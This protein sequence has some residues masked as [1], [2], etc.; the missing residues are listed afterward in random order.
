[1]DR[2]SAPKVVRAGR[3]AL[4]GRPNVGK[5]T[6]LNALLGER[7]AITSPHPQTT[8]AVVRGV[9]TRGDAQYVL[10]DTPGLH[11]AR[12]RLGQ[13]MNEAAQKTA[14][15]ADAVVFIMQ[16]PAEGAPPQPS[17]DDVALL[18]G[19]PARPTVVAVNKIDRVKK[20]DELLPFL[21]AI[22][23]LVA[24]RR[25]EAVVPISARRADGVDQLLDALRPL[26]PKQPM[27]C[28]PDTLSD[29][30]ARFFVA[31]FVREQVL[32]Q[33]RQEVPH[34]VAVVV[35][36]FDESGA[37]ARIE[38]TIHVARE[39]HKKIVIGASGQMLKAIGI[40]ARE[41]IERMLDQ[42][43]HLRLHVRATPGWMDNDARLRELGYGEGSES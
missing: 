38:A 24:S 2:S 20:K 26:L 29:Q 36:S 10:V 31:E 43:V 30:P 17:N 3:I 16:A 22:A 18:E 27:L 7:I 12:S 5:S 23:P 15:D 40:A 8:R 41:R 39:S 32:K 34:G 4:V 19:L 21:S 33:T 1:M 14:A 37:I 35:E 6:L 11:A 9:V 28:D 25:F 42:K 13:H